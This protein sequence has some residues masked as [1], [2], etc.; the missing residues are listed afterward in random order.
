MY[1]KDSKSCFFSDS[2]SF[3]G[4]EVGP[5]S[6]RPSLR[7]RE[8]VLRW[9]TSMSQKEVEAFCY[10]TPFLRRVIPGGAELVRIMKYAKE[11][12]G[13]SGKE[14]ID[15]QQR[16]RTYAEEFVWDSDRNTAFEAIKQAIA[17]NA[18]AAPNLNAQYHLAVD[19]SKKGLRGVLFQLGEVDPGTEATNTDKHQMMERI[20]MFISFRLAEVESR[21][22]NS[23]REALAVIRCLAEF[24]W[25]IIAS[26]YPVFVYTDH[27]ALKTLLTGP[28]N[29]AH[30]PI[31]KWQ[32]RFCEY[33]I[34][35]LHRPARTHFM[36]IADGLSRLPS[37]LLSSHFAEDVEGCRPLVGH[38]VQ[39]SGQ[40]TD[41]GVN[42]G[43]AMALRSS[44]KK[45]PYA[46]VHL[47]RPVRRMYQAIIM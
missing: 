2:L 35:L 45:P 34:R 12:S 46:L 29:D 37:R 44:V 41:V 14:T 20:I 6:L 28:D 33:D 24:R 18:M 15:W 16:Q 42:G 30:G 4:L 21:Y 25:M 27:E 31:A 8:T 3:V 47:V 43:M 22:S 1:L 10:L 9:P 13:S 17:N 23:E 26:P 11:C 32:E 39:V 5:N 38:L 19:A 7:K 40:V 36:A